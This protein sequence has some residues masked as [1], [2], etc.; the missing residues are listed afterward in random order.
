M[1]LGLLEADEG[2]VLT[3][4]DLSIGY[5]PQSLKIDP[6]IPITVKRLLTLARHHSNQE[7]SHA[8]GLVGAEKL[9]N[10]QVQHLSGGEFQRVLLARAIIGK[11][12]LLVLDEPAQGVDFNGEL[13]IYELIKKIRQETGCG[14]LLVSHDLHMVMA[15]TDTVVCLNGH[16]CC[17]GSPQMVAE[18]P[19]YLRLFG[20]RAVETLA[21]YRHNHDHI[22]LD[23]GRVQHADG[24]ITDHCYH[25]DGH[26]ENDHHDNNTLMSDD[27]HAG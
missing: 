21:V 1:V 24:T 4:P 22:H 10:T 23:D 14:I 17:T 11:P 6:T 25:E 19:E 5:V 3:A 27:K 18:N 20:Q 7:I 26:H 15:D 16:V 12:N 13:V 2:H 9:V 8:L